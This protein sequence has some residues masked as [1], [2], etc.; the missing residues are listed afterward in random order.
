[1]LD[2]NE[3]R[4]IRGMHALGASIKL[5]ARDLHMARNTVRKYLKSDEPLTRP[6]ERLPHPG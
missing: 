5:I 3:Y 4:T 6:F 2:M 1:M